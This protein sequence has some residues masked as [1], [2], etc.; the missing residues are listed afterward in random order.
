MKHTNGRILKMLTAAGTV[1][2][3]LGAC[4]GGGGGASN[5][6]SAPTG[7]ID[8][9]ATLRVATAAP[10]RNLDPYM[11]TSYGGRGFLTP[12]YDRLTMVDADDEIVPGLATDWE[13]VDDGSALELTLREDVSFNDGTPFDAESV[14]AN[15]ERGKT[16][17][18]STVVEDLEEINSVEVVDDTTVRLLVDKGEGAT[19]PSKFATNTGMMISPAV[20]EA[21]TDIRN[22][23]GLAGSG[24]YIV[25]TYVPQESLELVRRE[26]EYWDDEGGR[27]AG[28]T[29][30][31][32][33]EASTRINGIRTGA[34]DV[35]WVS[36]AN[37]IVEAQNLAQQG[38]YQVDEVEFRNVLGVMMRPEGALADR[39]I[40]QGVARAINP[41]ALSALFSETCVP[42][43]QMEPADSWAAADASYEYPYSFDEVEARQL[44]DSAGSGTVTLSFSAGSNTEKPANVIQSQL[45]A[46]GLDAELDPVPAQQAEPRNA[47]GEFQ[48]YVSNSFSPALD[49]AETVDKFVTGPYNFGNGDA[50]IA[51]LA[52]EAAD[53]RLSRDERADLYRQIWDK[54][55]AEALFVPICHQTNATIASPSVVGV[56][57]IPWVNTGIFDVRTAAIAE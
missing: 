41:D 33:P 19:L 21:G 46:V 54:T 5:G 52:D 40:R 10:S 18:G 34:I 7:E 28:M 11:Q 56:T 26:G 24:A 6:G 25:D 36:S 2:M 57:E 12:I 20:I 15:I 44:V 45:D 23:P 17:E 4:G 16:M 49:P 27:L 39:E 51:K 53:S 1:V 32:M 30:T 48:A 55:L 9:S 42:F 29:I 13:F 43:R 50:E 47:A 8:T 3:A 22:D 14:K 38:A 35:T 31:F 37:E